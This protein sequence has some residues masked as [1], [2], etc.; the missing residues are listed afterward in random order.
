MFYIAFTRVYVNNAGNLVG[1][2]DASRI[3]D[4]IINQGILCFEALF[5]GWPKVHDESGSMQIG[6]P[7]VNIGGIGFN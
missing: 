5:T 6:V 4:R 2:W 1:N 7:A 3:S